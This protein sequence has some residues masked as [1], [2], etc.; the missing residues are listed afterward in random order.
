LSSS[1]MNDFLTSKLQIME[2]LQTIHFHDLKTSIP[3][4]SSF[5]RSTDSLSWTSFLASFYMQIHDVQQGKQ[6]SPQFFLFTHYPSLLWIWK[7]YHT[8]ITY[9]GFLHDQYGLSFH[10]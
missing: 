1:E 3:I 5:L 8:C 4:V 6:L 9:T 10:F 2:T 7:T